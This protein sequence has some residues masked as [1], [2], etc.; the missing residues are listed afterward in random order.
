VGD[1]VANKSCDFR[2]LLREAIVLR[3]FDDLA[4]T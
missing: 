4:R 3:T 1:V 2:F